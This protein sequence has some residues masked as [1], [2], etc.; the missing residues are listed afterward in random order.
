[1]QYQGKGHPHRTAGDVLDAA[2]KDAPSNPEAGPSPAL[3]VVRAQQVRPRTLQGV[4]CPPRAALSCQSSHQS[5]LH[6]PE[7]APATCA[8]GHS[9]GSSSKSSGALWQEGQ[10]RDGVQGVLAR[11]PLP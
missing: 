9:Q 1:M 10:L 7:M 4:G 2:Q 3:H 5:R 6:K 11:E 8:E